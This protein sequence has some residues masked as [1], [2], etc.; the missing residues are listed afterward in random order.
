MD[1]RLQSTIFGIGAGQLLMKAAIF[2]VSRSSWRRKTRAPEE[3]H[4][5][6]ILLEEQ[7]N[8]LCR[9][10]RPATDHAMII[11]PWTPTRGKRSL[12]LHMCTEELASGSEWRRLATIPS[13]GK[14]RLKAYPSSLEPQKFTYRRVLLASS[15]VVRCHS[16]HHPQKSIA[17]PEKK[18]LSFA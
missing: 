12:S 4:L 1:S 18:T 16:H 13:A 15:M 11:L 6:E 7:E 14:P 5:R 9:H 2:E 3:Q 8:G 10:T 17:T